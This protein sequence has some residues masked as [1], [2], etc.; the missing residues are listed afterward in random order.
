MK[1]GNENECVVCGR[2]FKYMKR[3][4]SPID[5][6]PKEM[7]LITAHAGCRNLMKKYLKTKEELLNMEFE[8]FSKKFNVCK[9]KN[10]YD[11]RNN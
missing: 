8:L 10:E 4:T 11:Y 6:L 9:Y 3:Y 5:D 1:I 7:E 2:T